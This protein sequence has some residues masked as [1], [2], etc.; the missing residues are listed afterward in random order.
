MHF[1]FIDNH[2]RRRTIKGCLI[3]L[4]SLTLV[5]CAVGVSAQERLKISSTTSTDNSGL[6]GAL[7]P[8]FENRFGC[9]VDVIE[10]S[11]RVMNSRIG[12]LHIISL[13]CLMFE[14]SRVS[15]AESQALYQQKTVANQ[16]WARE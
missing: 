3:L 6:F 4:V 13:F 14:M 2:S 11:L 9:R 1:A 16:V 10:G 5:F 15:L 7:N 8:P 12:S